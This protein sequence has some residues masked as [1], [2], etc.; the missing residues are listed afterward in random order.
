M[1]AGTVTGLPSTRTSRCAWMCITFP[2]AP[3]IGR[4]AAAARAEGSTGV[5]RGGAVVRPS[6]VVRGVLGT[7]LPAGCIFFASLTAAE[8]PEAGLDAADPP[9]PQPASAVAAMTVNAVAVVGK[10]NR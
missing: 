2:S 10:V 7:A 4:P 8:D 3:S 9:A 6:A 5:S 1:Y